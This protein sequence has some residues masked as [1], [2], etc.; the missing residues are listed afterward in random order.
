M[1][2]LS[3]EMYDYVWK[4]KSF[5][6]VFFPDQ[7]ACIFVYQVQAALISPDFFVIAMNIRS[8]EGP[9]S[10]L[11]FETVIR[12]NSPRKA[13]SWPRRPGKKYTPLC[14]SE[15]LTANRSNF[16]QFAHSLSTIHVHF[17]HSSRTENAQKSKKKAQIYMCQK[18]AHHIINKLPKT[19]QKLAF[20]VRETTFRA[21]F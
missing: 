6:D 5:M 18:C 8:G 16:T 9:N 17:K 12:E 11:S 10:D 3:I 20:N 2:V 15:H 19:C 13:R 21:H 1:E 7:P 4:L 14:L